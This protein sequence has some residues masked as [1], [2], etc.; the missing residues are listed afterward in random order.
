MHKMH[1]TGLLYKTENLLFNQH[2]FLCCCITAGFE[3]AEINSAGIFNRIPVN[4]ITSCIHFLVDEFLN[5]FTADV[6][7]LENNIRIC[8][9]IKPECCH[10]IERVRIVIVQFEICGCTARFNTCNITTVKYVSVFQMRLNGMLINADDY[11]LMT[12]KHFVILLSAPYVN[13]RDFD[14]VPGNVVQAVLYGNY[15]ICCNQRMNGD[16]LS[17]VSG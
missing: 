4:M 1:N 6:I 11:T 14:S 10:R 12:D 3:C 13:Y 17:T 2:Y 9:Y 7:D 8:R 16:G 15:I 5:H